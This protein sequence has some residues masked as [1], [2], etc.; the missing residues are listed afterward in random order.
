MAIW[1]TVFYLYCTYG[2]IR[3]DD[4]NSIEKL[5][6][7]FPEKTSWSKNIRQFGDLDSTCI[8]FCY[9][10]I[11]TSNEIE[12]ISVR[13]DLRSLTEEQVKSICSFA[14]DNNLLARS[15]EDVL[16]P[17]VDGLK[18]IIKQSDACR[19]IKDPEQF[20]REIS[21]NGI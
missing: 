7:R 20:L 17:T 11:E 4:I 9:D 10:N 14:C 3:M 12:E 19:F 8:E 15:N 1:Q 6:S 16:E 21:R 13:L 5:S 2:K 18:K